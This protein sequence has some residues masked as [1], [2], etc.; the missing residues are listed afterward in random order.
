MD[1][2]EARQLLARADLDISELA[3]LVGHA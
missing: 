3:R 1:L 2:A